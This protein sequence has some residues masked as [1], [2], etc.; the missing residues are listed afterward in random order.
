MLA[1]Q[2]RQLY[3]RMIESLLNVCFFLNIT[4]S[5]TVVPGIKDLTLQ[6]VNNSR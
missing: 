2:K 1:V 6:G 4:Y 5:K 3:F